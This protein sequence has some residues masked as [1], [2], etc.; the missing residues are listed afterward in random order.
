MNFRSEYKKIFIVVIIIAAV[1]AANRFLLDN[2]IKEFAISAGGSAFHRLNRI[3]GSFNFLKKVSAF[4][5]LAENNERLKTENL[6]LIAKLGELDSL[7]KENSF[8][9]SQLGL[10]HL[11]SRESVMAGVISINRDGLF[12]SFIIGKGSADGIQKGMAVVGES[13]IMAGKIHEVFEKSSIVLTP[14]DPRLVIGARINESDILA[15]SRGVLN[16]EFY[17]DFIS[18]EEKVDMAAIIA[19]SGIDG[20][21]KGIPFGKVISAGEETADIFKKVKARILYEIPGP[22][23]LV[24]IN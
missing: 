16:G 11:A 23:V 17:L 9:R 18:P 3:A 1:I 15:S 21:P 22:D 14:D 8:L 10:A 19:T 4:P 24:I 5:D 20:L 12:S 6:S 13:G 2:K 7:K